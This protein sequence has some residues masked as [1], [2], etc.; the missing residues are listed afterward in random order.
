[1]AAVVSATRAWNITLRT[2]HIGVMGM[3]LGGHFFQVPAARLLPLLYLAI[4]TGAALGIVELSPDWRGLFEFRSLVIAAKLLLLVSIPWLWDYRVPILI[5][6]LVMASVGSHLPRQ[7]RH[8]SIL[9]LWS[10]PLARSQTSAS[11]EGHK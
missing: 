11:R 8:F 2:A 4:L 3:L 10:R 7:I 1:M 5:A 6:V 9:Q